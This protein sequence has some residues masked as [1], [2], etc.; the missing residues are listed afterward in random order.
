MAV[1][2]HHILRTPLEV[3]TSL[4][5]GHSRWRR[6]GHRSLN[7]EGGALRKGHH[8]RN[9]RGPGGRARREVGHG[10][11]ALEGESD[12]CRDGSNRHVGGGI[13]DGNLHGGDC[14]HGWEVDR[15]GRSSHLLEGSRRHDGMV[16]VNES[17]SGRCGEPR[18]GSG[19]LDEPTG[20]MN[21]REMTL[22]S[23]TQRTLEPLKSW[24]SNLSTATFKSA[25]VSNSTKLDEQSARMSDAERS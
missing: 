23:A 13:D 3:A 16:E 10:E 12:N 6:T 11:R 19:S 2:A 22:T 20:R 5:D 14:S 25:A 4:S 24:L 8:D 7:D 1:D 18:P 17:G 15:D 9:H 21:D